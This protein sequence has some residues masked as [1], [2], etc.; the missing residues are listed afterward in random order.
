M[1]LL[2]VFLLGREFANLL[3]CHLSFVLECVRDVCAAGVGL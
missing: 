1:Y 2:C 3:F